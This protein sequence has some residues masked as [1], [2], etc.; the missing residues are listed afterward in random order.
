MQ[1][2]GLLLVIGLGLG[3]R[4][5][6][7]HSLPPWLAEY[8]GD[9]LWALMVFLGVGLVFPSW[10]TCRV[11]VVALAFAFAIEFSQLY[12]GQWLQSLRQNR[13]GALVL[14]RGFLWSDLLCYT[15]GVLMGVGAEG[16]TRMIRDRGRKAERSGSH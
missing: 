1:L 3:S 6:L 11:A 15:V 16:I 13:I 12:Q 9:T 2:A 10:S 8:A 4:S 7:A 14:G 5:R